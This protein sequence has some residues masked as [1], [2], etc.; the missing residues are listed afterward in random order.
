MNIVLRPYVRPLPRKPIRGLG[1][2]LRALLLEIQISNAKDAHQRACADYASEPSWDNA[3]RARV[4][5][6]RL[7]DLRGKREPEIVARLARR[8]R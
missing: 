6:H 3:I 7:N 5:G 2:W 4:A 1:W 8:G